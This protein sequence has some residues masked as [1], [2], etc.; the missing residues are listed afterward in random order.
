[1]TKSNERDFNFDDELAK[2]QPDYLYDGSIPADN[3][4]LD[5]VKLNVKGVRLG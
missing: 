3:D 5:Y 2:E 4:E 1:M